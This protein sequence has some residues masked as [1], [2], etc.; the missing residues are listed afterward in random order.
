MSQQKPILIVKISLSLST[1][2]FDCGICSNL[3]KFHSGTWTQT[4]RS[5]PTCS[6]IQLVVDTYLK[7]INRQMCANNV[8]MRD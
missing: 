1:T 3:V 8:L 6:A 2:I 5:A 7:D 4:P